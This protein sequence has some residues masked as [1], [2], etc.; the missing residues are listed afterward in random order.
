M[1]KA[2]AK[3]DKLGGAREKAMRARLRKICLA[4]PEAEE[5]LAWGQPVFR[6]GGSIFASFGTGHGGLHIGF[7]ARNRDVLKIAGVV[8]TSWSKH[9][10][11]MRMIGDDETA[12]SLPWKTIGRLMAESC[13]L[14]GAQKKKKRR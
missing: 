11:V 13:E 4:L 2:K 6:V 12:A 7:K 14:V 3:V 8:E 9:G 1:A 10:W 5:G